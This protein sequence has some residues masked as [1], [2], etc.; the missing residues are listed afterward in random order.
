MSRN[1]PSDEWTDAATDLCAWSQAEGF[2]AFVIVGFEDYARYI[3]PQ[4]PSAMIAKWLRLLADQYEKLAPENR[5]V[6]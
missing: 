4:Y 1:E 2:P 6:N 3:G 5:A